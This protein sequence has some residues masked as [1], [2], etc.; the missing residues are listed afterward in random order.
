[1][2][3]TRWTCARST[4]QKC[5][6]SLRSQSFSLIA[7]GA[8]ADLVVDMNK[9]GCVD[10]GHGF[11]ATMVNAIH[12]GACGGDQ[13]VVGGDPAG[14]VIQAHNGH[15]IYHSGDTDVF[16]DM[17]IISD[18]Y[19]PDV[20]L[21]CIGGHYTMGPPGAAYAIDNLLS[22][23][24]IVVPMHYGTFPVLAGTPQELVQAITRRD[25]MVARV[26]PGEA[27]DLKGRSVTDLFS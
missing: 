14:W 27:F 22:T 8:P 17:R 2:S 16:G 11:K 1:M 24:K 3:A 5:T 12:S 20:A 4:A 18:M 23:V 19:K 7:N 15:V 6:A 9:G 13:L 21:L 10:I 26:Q 25:V